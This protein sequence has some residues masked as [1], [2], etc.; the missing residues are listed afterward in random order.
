MKKKLLTALLAALMLCAAVIPAGAEAEAEVV[1]LPEAKLSAMADAPVG[2]YATVL[3]MQVKSGGY[4]SM[5][6]KT[7]DHD[8]LL[9]HFAADTVL[10]DT[11]TGL[12]VLETDIKTG[13]K[14]YIY[15]D[16]GMDMSMPPQTGV[17]AVLTN[18]DD[19][20]APAHLLTAEAINVRSDSGPTVLCEN[21]GMRV[22]LPADV[23]IRPLAIKDI[24]TLS[25]IRIGTR[26]F[27][28]YDVVA[29][30]YP[31]QAAAT[32][33][34]LPP[35][36]D[37]TVKIAVEGD[38]LI[39]GGGRVE[40]GTAMV[41]VRAVAEALGYSVQWNGSLKRVTL[42]KA[43]A[44][45]ALIQIGQD[46]YA[47]G[48]GS[49]TSLGA[50]AYEVCGTTWVPAELFSKLGEPVVLRGQALHIGSAEQV[51]NP[52]LEVEDASAFLAL[53][54]KLDAPAGAENVRYS[55]IDGDLAQV[56]F[57]LDG[58]DY[59]YRASKTL[60]GDISGIYAEL[61]DEAV[62][63]CVDGVDFG[64]CVDFRTVKSGGYIASWHAGET[65]Y[66]LS[67]LSPVAEQAFTELAISIAS[68]AARTAADAGLCGLPLATAE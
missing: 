15:R 56:L 57:S 34:V 9:L 51:P 67:T 27:A 17:R 42:K 7:G 61:E 26:F 65:Q 4:S 40:D 63:I 11:Q 25:D 39:P 10:M 60:E 53:G 44:T 36:T 48:G 1:D 62:G 3:Q 37:C 41:P 66:S 31:G 19:M 33:V 46:R 23:D 2:E 28:W 6:V 68:E 14:V 29:E 21:G 22:L 13:D 24:V 45:A 43:G 38:M 30:S 49:G 50:A 35:Q 58:A 18:L 52:I 55:I 20:H 32:K 8:K 47:F 59:T 16:E 64:V 5:L 54:L 12:P